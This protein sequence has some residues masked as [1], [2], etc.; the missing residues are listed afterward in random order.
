MTPLRF[1]KWLRAV[2]RRGGRH[3]SWA[4]QGQIAV[5]FL[6]FMALILLLA[7]ATMNLGEVA[8]LKTTTANASDAGALAGASWV[9]SAENE[10]A[11]I[12]KGMWLNILMVQAIFAFPFCWTTC[13][14]LPW[15][16]YGVLTLVN[17][18]VLKELAADPVGKAA[19]ENAHAAAL[20]T[21]I[22]NAS[23]DDTSGTVNQQI[24]QLSDQFKASR[25]VPSS[26]TFN[27][28]RKGADKVARPSWV[29]I[30]VAFLNER[31]AL[32]MGVFGAPYWCWQKCPGCCI[33][34]LAGC[35]LPCVPLSGWVMSGGSGPSQPSSPP[36]AK[37]PGVP[38]FSAA[39][40]LAYVKAIPIPRPGPCLTCPWLIT[41]GAVASI[42]RPSGIAHGIGNVVVTVTQHREGG[43]PL[44]FW[45]MR[46]PDQIRSMA[47]AHYNA[48]KVSLW[49]DPRSKAELVA[50]Q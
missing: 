9:A 11:E 16:I 15:V 43:S 19:W 29:Q 48:A 12:A 14:W 1:A 24:Q 5:A 17:F 36:T 22:Q 47:T 37:A 26:V 2:G 10:F 40:W 21:A 45:T 39:A 30:D 38:I 6:V 42:V 44:R 8:R 33:P 7:A 49:P 32:T 27:W 31:P 46:Y 25:T 18:V 35:C 41:G 4:Q 13:H 23:I 28:T 34:C 50:V 3:A 20:F